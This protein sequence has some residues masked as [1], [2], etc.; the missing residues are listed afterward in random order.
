MFTIK[1]DS[2]IN[3][4]NKYYT[5]NTAVKQNIIISKKLSNG[6]KLLYLYLSY[7]P[8]GSYIKNKSIC[9]KLDISPRTLLNKRREL[10]NL[11]L[12]KEAN[13]DNF[14]IRF[15]GSDEMSAHDVHSKWSLN[16]DIK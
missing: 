5:H 15:I 16:N 4:N 8:N 12:L 10:S 1:Y 3:N 11:N 7:L 2:F 6:A 13:I 9:N 14:S